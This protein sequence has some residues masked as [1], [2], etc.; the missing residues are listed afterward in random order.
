MSRTTALLER[1]MWFWIAI[2]VVSVGQ[3]AWWA[4][5]RDPPF[6]VLSYRVWPVRAGGVLWID[7]DVRRDLARDCHVELSSSIVDSIGVRW[8]LGTTQSV[9]PEGIRELDA[10]SP[11]KLMRKMQLPPG[12]T[13]GPA[14]VLSS[15]IYR[16]NPLHDVARPISVQT[17]FDFEVL[18]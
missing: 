18:P 9:S 5:D 16:C 2:L 12:M 15:M 1:M 10:K 7:A 14:S 3:L 4:M 11:G 13:P 17:R 6:Q 8:D